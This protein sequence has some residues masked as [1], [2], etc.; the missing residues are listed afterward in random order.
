MKYT[1]S[2]DHVTRKMSWR[3][4]VTT[5]SH[6][7]NTNPYFDDADLVIV[8]D[9]HAGESYISALW[10]VR[11]ERSNPELPEHGPLQ[12]ALR[13][14]LKPH[15]DAISLARIAGDWDCPTDRG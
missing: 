7:F 15:L 1:A 14:V 4:G 2:K 13:N 3:F 6:L 8:G 9:V 12:A 5:Y 10:T 11:I